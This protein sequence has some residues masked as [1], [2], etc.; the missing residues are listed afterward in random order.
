MLLLNLYLLQKKII[1]NK[2]QHVKKFASDPIL[3]RN[4]DEHFS[5]NLIKKLKLFFL[6]GFFLSK[7]K[8][9]ILCISAFVPVVYKGRFIDVRQWHEH[10]LQ[11]TSF[12]VKWRSYCEV[13]GASYNVTLLVKRAKYLTVEIFF[14][15]LLFKLSLREGMLSK[16]F[17][18]KKIPEELSGVSPSLK[19]DQK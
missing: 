10:A 3:L 12:S 17:I 1:S 18:K 4:R 15:L 7:K 19:N 13:G 8:R 5:S 6:Q 2:N 11:E 14:L 16:Q 9:L